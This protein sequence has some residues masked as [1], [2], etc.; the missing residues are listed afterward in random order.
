MSS[1]HY[2][3]FL[4]KEYFALLRKSI[5]LHQNEGFTCLPKP[6]RNGKIVVE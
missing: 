3:H 4:Q 5:L 6:P 2:N 1:F